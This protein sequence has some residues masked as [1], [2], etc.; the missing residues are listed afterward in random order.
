MVA[1][2]S[3]IFVMLY[4]KISLVSQA[5]AGVQL[6]ITS[7]VVFHHQAHSQRDLR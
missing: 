4:V 5:L 2:S 7:R 1:T 6:V 3:V